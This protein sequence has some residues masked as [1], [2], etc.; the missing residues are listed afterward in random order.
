MG[1]FQKIFNKNKMTQE[2]LQSIHEELS[3]KPLYQ[4]LKTDRQ[5]SLCRYSDIVESE[6]VIFVNFQ[7]GSRINYTL[8][9][10]MMIA[11]DSENDALDLSANSASPAP[12]SVNS[13]KVRTSAVVKENPIHSLLNKQKPN[14]VGIDISLDLNMPPKELY[15]VLASSFENADSEITEF[16]VADI[17]IEM[18][19]EAVKN[20][21]QKYYQL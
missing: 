9:S 14:M 10:E 13:A 11:L 15:K 17:N 4:W 8:M 2:Q 18:I 21:I 1:W 3:R 19:R 6:G 12:S 20:A 7:D 16:I 5:G